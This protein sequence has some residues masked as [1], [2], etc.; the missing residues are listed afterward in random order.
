MFESARQIDTPIAAFSPA[1]ADAFADRMLGILNSAALAMATSVGH[2]TG[3]FD[4][5]SCR[6]PSTSAEIAAQAS[7]SERYVREWLAV[8]VTG[9]FVQYAPEGRKY[10]L[11]PEHA[12]VL[13]SQSARSL[14]TT[15]QF[16]AVLARVEDL[17]V[18][19][20][21]EG[22][23]VG[24]EAF[25]RFHEVMGEHSRHTVT[26][27][28]FDSIIP[29]APLLTGRLQDGIDVLDVGCGIGRS[30]IALASAY[31]N[32]R[33]SGF[34]LCDEAI[35][36]ARSRA[37]GL[38]LSNLEFRVRDA[39]E[40]D[41]SEVYD[42]VTAFDSIHDQARPATVLANIRRSLRPR[43]VFLMQDIETSS[44]LHENLDH[45]LGPFLYWISYGHCMTVS[46][47]QGG[48]GLGACWGREKA[49]EMLVEA[50]FPAPDV[51]KL[52]HDLLNLYYVMEV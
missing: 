19:A 42:L 9:G 52:P 45:P 50:G 37:R 48:E 6:L 34:D 39:A 44:E 16:L 43:G 15:T 18:Q 11:P 29:L 1:R 22:G 47:A 4:A 20:F 13:C 23:G 14:A 5:M 41:E 24:Y 25:D 3:L 46:L 30:L 12:L 7:L 28:L 10:W 26:P 27:A 2:R 17:I 21:R 33:F 36:A 8:M 31:P 49:L 51:S 32:S 40:L 38:G 35:K